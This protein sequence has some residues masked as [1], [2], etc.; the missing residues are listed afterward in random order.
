MSSNQ[1]FCFQEIATAPPTSCSSEFSISC[2]RHLV[3]A[4]LWCG[5]CFRNIILVLFGDPLSVPRFGVAFSASFVP[6]FA[7]ESLAENFSCSSGK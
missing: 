2:C 4:S 6:I 1:Y 7:L 5:V 3:P